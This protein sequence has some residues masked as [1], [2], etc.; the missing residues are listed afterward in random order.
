METDPRLDLDAETPDVDT[1]TQPQDRLA[2]EA[3]CI[4]RAQASVAAGRLVSSE[5]VDARINSLA[6]DHELPL[7]R[8][9]Q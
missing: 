6:T 3:G 9:G 8:A 7:P 5:A 1:E 4:A 2:W